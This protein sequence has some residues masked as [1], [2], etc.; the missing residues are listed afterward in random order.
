YDSSFDDA[1]VVKKQERLNGAGKLGHGAAH[2]MGGFGN[3]LG[4]G[5]GEEQKPTSQLTAEWIEY[6]IIVGGEAVRTVRRPVFDCLGP[7]ARAAKKIPS[8]ALG[9][10]LRDQ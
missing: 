1:G 6:Q 4:G 10:E 3:A 9:D 7:A 8:G 5:G 2:L